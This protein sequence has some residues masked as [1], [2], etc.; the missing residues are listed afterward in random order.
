MLSSQ[1]YFPLISMVI[2]YMSVIKYYYCIQLFWN[3]SPM[4]YRP[5]PYLIR[6]DAG[7]LI[8]HF[9]NEG[10]SIL[11][12]EF[13]VY[14]TISNHPVA[15]Y[16]VVINFKYIELFNY[17]CNLYLPIRYKFSLSDSLGDTIIVMNFFS[18][19]V[20]TTFTYMVSFIFC[21]PFW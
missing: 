1:S 10:L 8:R 4:N 18:S 11:P 15:V 7:Y 12:G 14:Y 13:Y 20:C 21:K 17:L 5:F 6:M 3:C 9:L 2:D 16:I 19:F